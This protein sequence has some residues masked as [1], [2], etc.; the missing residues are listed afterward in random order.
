MDNIR[1]DCAE[2]VHCPLTTLVVLPGTG[3]NGG[4]LFATRVANAQIQWLSHS[5]PVSLSANIFRKRLKTHLF[6]NALRHVARVMRYKNL[7][8]TYLF[9]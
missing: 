6:R 8:L 1:E 9:F 2:T 5:D 4:T 3:L 7:R